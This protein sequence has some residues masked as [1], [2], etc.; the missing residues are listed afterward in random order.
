[1]AEAF[2]NFYAEKK[3]VDAYAESGGTRPAFRVNPLAVEVMREAGIDISSQKPKLL[4]PGMV[5]KAERVVTMGCRVEDACPA[6]F[7]EA[8]DWKIEDP[9]GKG[10]EKF[11]EVREVIRERVKKLLS[12]FSN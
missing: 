9:A 7:V 12:D 2:F 6:L 1:M 8:E 4:Q 10:I 3:G 5:K 11:R